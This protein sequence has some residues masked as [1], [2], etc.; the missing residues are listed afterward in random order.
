MHYMWRDRLNLTW[1]WNCFFVRTA[2]ST[3][4][5]SSI[6]RMNSALVAMGEL[7]VSR[8]H[9]ER[10]HDRCKNAST[11]NDNTVDCEWATPIPRVVWTPAPFTMHVN[12]FTS[13]LNVCNPHQ[14]IQQIHE[15]KKK[16]KICSQ[17]AKRPICLTSAHRAQHVTAAAFL[18]LF[19]N[20]IAQTINPDT[21]F[22][23]KR[24][25]KWKQTDKSQHNVSHLNFRFAFGELVCVCEFEC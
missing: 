24:F 3:Y 21:T 10:T 6:W 4:L 15:W 8:W 19:A 17:S 9:S 13:R 16:P 18:A 2:C 20:T 14:L 12:S 25:D 11:G 22:S 23:I 7:T 1:S 5:L